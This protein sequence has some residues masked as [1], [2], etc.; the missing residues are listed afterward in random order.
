M[1]GLILNSLRH[2]NALHSIITINLAIIVLSIK[3]IYI[4][5]IVLF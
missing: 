5:E 3:M 2:V 1:R 4:M